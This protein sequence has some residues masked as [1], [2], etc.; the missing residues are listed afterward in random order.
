MERKKASDFPPEVL[1]LFDRY[2]H[3][4]M[5]RREFLDRSSR[6]AVGGFTAL[7]MLEAL[8]PNYALAQQVPKDDR[9]IK[10]GYVE[11]DSPRGSGKIR[12]YMAHPAAG[13][14]HPG[15]ALIHENRGLT[16]YNEDVARRLALQGYLVIAPDALSPLGGYPGN[17]DEAMKA[18]AKLDP[19]KRDEDL[20]TAFEAVG[21]RPE[22]NGRVGALG[23]CF[24]GGIVGKMAV[25]YPTLAAAAMFYPTARP[26]AADTAKIKAPLLILLGEKDERFT[27]AWLGFESTLKD[28]GVRYQR[29]VYEN[30]DHA[31]HNEGGARYNEAA[32]KDAWARTLDFFELHL[33]G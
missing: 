3:G 17:D 12:S 4:T 24:G 33:K 27:P 23:F 26:N 25:R 18:F 14:R 5:S 30:A 22:S 8:S 1:K 10:A 20:V 15:V 13:S 7:A 2:I 19:A 9:R 31:F 29:R 11:Y 32:A 16:P 6:Y 28:A 21:K